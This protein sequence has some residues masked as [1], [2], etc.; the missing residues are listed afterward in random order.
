MGGGVKR[1]GEEEEEGKG[2]GR[3]RWGTK[4]WRSSCTTHFLPCLPYLLLLLLFFLLLFLLL[5]PMAGL[6]ALERQRAHEPGIYI[7]VTYN[8]VYV[9]CLLELN[10]LV[11]M[12]HK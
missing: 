3:T 7:H 8:L 4:R 6:D 12:L 5:L 1:R 10:M 11:F 9:Y 2:V